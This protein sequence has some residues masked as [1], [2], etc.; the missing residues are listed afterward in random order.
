VSAAADLS[1]IIATRNHAQ[2]LSGT[3]LALIQQDLPPTRFEVIVADNGSTDATR[4]VCETFAKIMPNLRF[5]SDPRPGQ[6]VGWHT[7]LL[8]AEGDA[9]AFI[10]DDVRPKPGW[11]S[12]VARTFADPTVGLAT[13]PIDP[14][15]D[16]QPP[17]WQHALILDN[18]CGRW[19]G[20]WGALDFGNTTRDIPPDFV[21][22]S[23]FL[24]RKRALV[25]VGGFHPGNMPLAL[26]RFV[27]DG[28]VAAGRPIA[29]AGWR[30]VYEPEAR[31]LH[32]MPVNRLGAQEVKNW[33]T[34]EG[35]VTSYLVLRRLAAEHPTASRADLIDLV[36]QAIPD[37]R[38]A[39][40]GRGYLRRKMELPD[41]IRTVFETS[42]PVGFHLHQAAF[43][44]DPAFAEWVLRPNY[45]DIDACYSHP[46]LQPGA[47]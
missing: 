1:V 14:L 42:G 21:W 3:L 15:F 27:G 8:A 38:V 43:A 45:L 13:G 22:G 24:V 4:T 25:Q 19:S 5:V 35:I 11:A 39:E 28:D 17:A 36:R 12:A 40:I 41:D 16:A 18:E 31:V 47:R 37:N 10:D 33:I 44:D 34:G 46:A 2:K 6:L 26:F 20:L 32:H 7:A 9:L 30:V 29:A 23:N